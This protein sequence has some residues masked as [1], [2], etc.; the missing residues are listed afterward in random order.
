[1]KIKTHLLLIATTLALLFMASAVS[2]A[3]VYKWVDKDGNVH[4]GAQ[5]PE[6][7]GAAQEMKIRVNEPAPAPQ[8]ADPKKSSKSKGNGK[9]KADNS[10]QNAEVEKKNAEIKKENCSIAKKRLASINVGGRLYEVDEKG[11]R[12]FWDDA[13]VAAKRAEAQELINKWCN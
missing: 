8:A 3:K 6:Q 9:D 5:K 11:E 13:T 10:K 2:A 1:M 12:K 7:S 4:Y